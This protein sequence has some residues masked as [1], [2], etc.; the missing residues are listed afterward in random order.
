MARRIKAARVPARR[1][2]ASF[3]RLLLTVAAVFGGSGF[4]GRRLVAHM[5][6]RGWRVRVGCRHPESVG[7]VRVAGS[8]GQVEPMFC[9]LRSES[10]LRRLLEG[11]DIAVNLVGILHEEGSQKF[12]A[13]HRDG[14][15]SVARLCREGGVAKLVHVSAIGA[16]PN[17]RS[18]YARSKGEG[19]LAVR[20]GFADATILRPSVIFG[21][22]DQFLT[23]FA[24]M[25]RLS[26]V[27]PVVGAGTRFQPVYVEDVCQAVLAA[28]ED[29]SQSSDLY[30]LGGPRVYAFRELMEL[31]LE[32]LSARRVIAPIPFPVAE[33]I[34]RM[35]QLLPAPPL[36]YDQ[37]LLLR[38]D[39]VVAPGASTLED[40]GIRPAPVE[41]VIDRCIAHLRHGGQYASIEEE[42]RST[43]P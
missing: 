29:A 38:S 35:A 13:I 32:R 26:P 21:E 23:R 14:A 36:T 10:L 41:S 3:A 8:V 15:E 1:L 7:R 4:V 11:C 27:L 43:R 39:N 6:R 17:A 20:A 40:L 37:T 22:G 42:M 19:E 18:R 5:A 16:D 33:M 2:R 28:L 12:A 25:A 24:G 9:N 30:E 31:L 34:G